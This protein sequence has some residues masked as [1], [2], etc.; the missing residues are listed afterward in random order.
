MFPADHSA[1]SKLRNYL[2]EIIAA[3]ESGKIPA[4][5]QSEYSQILRE[6]F[7]CMTQPGNETRYAEMIPLVVSLRTDLLMLVSGGRK[8]MSYAAEA[9]RAL[10]EGLNK[11]EY[12]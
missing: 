4:A 11:L 8:R 9:A 1:V 5:V 2:P 10:A 7:A 3:L 6:A 12:D